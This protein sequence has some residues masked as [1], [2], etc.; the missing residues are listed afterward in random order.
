MKRRS[1]M[2]RA[3]IGLV[4]SAFVFA[5]WCGWVLWEK[6]EQAAK[7]REWKAGMIGRP[8]R[9]LVDLWGEPDRKE[10]V[11]DSADELLYWKR[12]NG[13]RVVR[14]SQ[15]RIESIDSWSR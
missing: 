3:L 11:R 10:L 1:F 2:C 14:T 13:L 9:E 8:Q 12:N 6:G 7:W 4:V 15:G 5:A